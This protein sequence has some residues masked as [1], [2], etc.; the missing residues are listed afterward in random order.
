M[1]MVRV[2]GVAFGLIL[3]SFLVLMWRRER[4][5]ERRPVEAR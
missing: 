2:A 3:T 5:R 4:R 1:N